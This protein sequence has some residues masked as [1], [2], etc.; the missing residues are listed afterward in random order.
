[1]KL[2]IF[3]ALWGM[4]GPFEEQ[5]ER[6]AAAGYDGIDG[7]IGAS[8]LKPG[9]FSDIV[10]SHGLKLNMAAQIGTVAELEPTLKALAEYKPSKIGVQGGRDSMT[11]D[12]GCAFFEEA[13]RLEQALGI[14]IAHET[15]RG[16]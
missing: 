14:P 7:F 13:L 4:T 6:I 1:M 3:R 11:R 9:K 15:H 2:L 16:R 12:E 10:S 8:T 5:L